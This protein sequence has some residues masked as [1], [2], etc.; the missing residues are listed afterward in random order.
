MQRI[1]YHTMYIRLALIV[2]VMIPM[3]YTGTGWKPY[4]NPILTYLEGI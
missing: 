2:D 3:T 1:S 4:L